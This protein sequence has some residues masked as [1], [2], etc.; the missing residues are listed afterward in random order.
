MSA[1][2]QMASSAGLTQMPP[3]PLVIG[4]MM[5]GD[6]EKAS[7]LGSMVHFVVLGALVFGVGYAVLFATLDDASIGTGALIGLAHGVVVGAIVLPMMA[8]LHP[9][10]SGASTGPVSVEGGQV[11]L[12]A[13]GIFGS[14]WGGMTPVGMLA[15]H[16]VYGVVVAVV[17]SWLI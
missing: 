10:M 14:R 12:S 1:M 7:R 9:R 4:S 8:A 13:P 3:M 2:M 16:V 5:S 6:E 15:G 11:S 17:Y